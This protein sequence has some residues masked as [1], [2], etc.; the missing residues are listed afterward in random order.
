MIALNEIIER[1]KRPL[2]V[3]VTMTCYNHEKYIDKAI[4]GV[5]MQKT[6]FPVNIV[7]HDD[8]STDRSAEII[9]RY[10]SENP[11]I[12]A[13][14]EETN[15]YQN[16][17]S[18][19]TKMLPYYTGKYLA[20][21]ECDDFWLDENKLQLQIDY[22]EANPDCIAV[23]SN[24][25]PVNK[26]S[27]YDE[28]CRYENETDMGFQDT[29]EGDFQAGKINLNMAHQLATLV[30]R[31]FWKFMT[32]E[33]INI[34][35]G[36]RYIGDFKLFK[37]LI[38]QGRIHYF[39][40]RFA[41][42]RRVIGEGDSYSARMARMGAYEKYK[43]HVISQMDLYQMLKYFFREEYNRRHYDFQKYLYIILM[44]I[45]GRIRF[46][47]SVIEDASLT[48]YKFKNIPL[49]IWPVFPFYAAYRTA[50]KAADFFVR[51][52]RKF[53]NKHSVIK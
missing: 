8:A 10:A 31:N 39:K 24:I 47:R 7:I 17:K 51:N 30:M 44:E 34:Y 32:P 23:Y 27:Q 43:R 15:Y 50:G 41:A 13:I 48:Q 25:L 38:G 11:N 22:L 29:E 21:C 28:S 5:L 40:E 18:F 36:V 4:R 26:Y 33:E 37:L 16:G 2:S 42:Y 45:Q 12:T 14:I 35:L 3:T 52:I 1:D 19:F 49:Y 53:K 46:N 20:Y 6:N 9:R